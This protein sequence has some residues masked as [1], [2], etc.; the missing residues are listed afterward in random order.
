MPPGAA[1]GKSIMNKTTSGRA[2]QGN[3]KEE[4][5]TMTC[6]M[7]GQEMLS[8]EDLLGPKGDMKTPTDLMEDSHKNR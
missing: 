6:E 1:D 5:E 4:T 7:A 2:V 8:Q 3:L